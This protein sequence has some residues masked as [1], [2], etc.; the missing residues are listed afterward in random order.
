MGHYGCTMMMM[1]I[2]N[3]LSTSYLFVD[4]LSTSYLSTVALFCEHTTSEILTKVSPTYLVVVGGIFVV[5]INCQS[6]SPCRI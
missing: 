2:V 3:R 4:R 1:M 5:A 6:L